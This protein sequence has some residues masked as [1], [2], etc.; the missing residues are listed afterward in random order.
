MRCL[1][2]GLAIIRYISGLAHQVSGDAAP[3]WACLVTKLLSIEARFACHGFATTARLGHCNTF[4]FFSACQCMLAA[5]VT[6][7]VLAETK[8]LMSS[9]KTN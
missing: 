6:R 4:V 3:A 8:A 2:G 7:P 1:G 9:V 5:H